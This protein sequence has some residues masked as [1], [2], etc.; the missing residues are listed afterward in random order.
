MLFWFIGIIILWEAN[1]VIYSWLMKQFLIFYNIIKWWF[2][3]YMTEPHTL[4]Q[5]YTQQQS[6]G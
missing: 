4:V 2:S 3:F 6:Q 5:L 1:S